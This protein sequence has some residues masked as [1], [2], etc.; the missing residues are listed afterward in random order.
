[1][2][3]KLQIMVSGSLN[4]CRFPPKFEGPEAVLTALSD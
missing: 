4:S 3:L 2:D 1:M